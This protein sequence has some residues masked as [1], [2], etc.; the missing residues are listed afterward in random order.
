MGACLACAAPAS[1]EAWRALAALGPRLRLCFDCSSP[2]SLNEPWPGLQACLERLALD[3]LVVF[4]PDG[5]QQPV[6]AVLAA[7]RQRVA[8]A[9]LPLHLTARR[10]TLE[11]LPAPFCIQPS[12]Y[13]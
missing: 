3:R 6:E 11:A 4:V 8:T 5:P 12:L 9:R 7:W 2:E 1:S 10:K 13:D